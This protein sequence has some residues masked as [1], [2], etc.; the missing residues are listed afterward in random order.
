[1]AGLIFKVEFTE[2]TSAQPDPIVIV[3]GMMTS[4]NHDLMLGD[5]DTD[6]GNWVFI[7]PARTVYQALIDRLEQ[8]G[9][10]KDENLFIAH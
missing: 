4:F 2:L 3:P 9:F 7:L 8:A 6:G 1:M 10:A 5:T